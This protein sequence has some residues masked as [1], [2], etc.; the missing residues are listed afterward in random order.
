MKE[1]YTIIYEIKKF[2]GT[3][4]FFHPVAHIAILSPK[5]PSYIQKIATIEVIK[6]YDIVVSPTDTK[7]LNI[8][9]DLSIKSIE[10]TFNKNKNSKSLG[11]N[12]L[13][14]DKTSMASIQSR[15]NKGM[16]L[17]F[18]TTKEQNIPVYL[19]VER[20][21]HLDNCVLQHSNIPLFVKLF[22]QK[23]QT[24]IN[25]SL[26]LKLHDQFIKPSIN[27]IELLVNK[28]NYLLM[29]RTIYFVENFDGKKLIPFQTKESV[30]IPEKLT[31]Q[32]FNSVFKEL[33]AT[34][35]IEVQG[36]DYNINSENPLPTIKFSTGF[37]ENNYEAI[38]SFNYG[39]NNFVYGDK[40]AYKLKIS[41]DEENNIFVYRENRNFQLEESFIDFIEENGLIKTPSF[42]YKFDSKDPFATLNFFIKHKNDWVKRGWKIEFPLLNNKEIEFSSPIMDESYDQ[43]IDWFEVNIVIT[44]GEESVSFSSLLKNIK[45]GDRIFVLNS[46]K[47]FIIPQEWMERFETLSKFATVTEHQV[48]VKKIHGAIIEGLQNED[49]AS[50]TAENLSFELPEFNKPTLLNAE[51]RT[52]Q[53]HGFNWLYNHYLNGLGACLAD[54]MGLGKTLQ[55]ITL[56]CK[57]KEETTSN[58]SLEVESTVQLSLFENY[59]LKRRSLRAL[60]IMPSS[61]IFNWQREIKRFAP[62]LLCKT[63]VG[64]GREKSHQ[65]LIH[66]DVILTTY[67]LVIK[68]IALLKKIDFEIIIIDEAQYIKNRDSKVFKALSSMNAKCKVSLSGTPIENSLA[69]LWSQMQFIN[70]DILHTYPKFKKMYQDPIEKF[71]DQD[72]LSELKTLLNPFILR[73]KKSDVLNDLPDLDEVI[74]YCEMEEDQASLIEKEKSKARNFI[75]GLDQSKTG[76]LKFH[77]FAALIRLRQLANH[78]RLMDDSFTESSSKFIEVT[79]SISSL[80]KSNNKLILFS[81][82]K[83]H[84][85]IYKEFLE[86]EG[87]SYSM[88]TGDTTSENR[89]KA[90]DYFNNN[91]D[92]KI[93][94]ISIK[95]GGTGLNLTSANYVFLL[96][97]WWNPFIEEQAKA[98]A[99]RIGQ[100]RKVTVIKFITSDS[101]EEK[102]LL[103]QNNKLELV[104]DFLEETTLANIDMEM[105]SEL[106]A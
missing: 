8:V 98:R 26:Y 24:G 95:A 90:V 105:I 3:V 100:T 91:E 82:F 59:N 37:S 9:E 102:I 7:L 62:S 33:L 85:N 38:P 103:L 20:K 28:P 46:D 49:A 40:Q 57:V 1:N 19:D 18:K 73:R 47:V 39:S 60:I 71:K 86:N 51:L 88:I 101:I 54:D 10:T 89:M 5:G 58:G 2:E 34:A 77:V 106:L 79:N 64:P 17:F 68:D 81:S 74:H 14:E 36:F 43:K 55:A 22:F 92:C 30:F 11:I 94:L 35:D 23:T 25:A 84:L 66:F 96:D 48:I 69:D 29:D 61:L 63:H 13:F 75:L 31:S 80:L 83:G 104:Q 50:N 87:I 16:D 70:P 4:K 56:L 12:Q 27:K 52:Y 15:V 45:S 65:G 67:P 97:P 93:I 21:T 44:I 32:Y 78:P 76:E 53:K 42:R 41:I 72:A 6:S 99:H